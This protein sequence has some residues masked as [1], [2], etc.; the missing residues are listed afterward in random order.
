MHHLDNRLLLSQTN[1]TNYECFE[2]AVLK[3]ALKLSINTMYN[4]CTTEEKIREKQQELKDLE[5]KLKK[6]KEELTE[7][8]L[9]EPTVI[10]AEYLHE[11]LCHQNHIDWC[12][13]HYEKW[14]NL[15]KTY[16]KKDYYNRAQKIIENFA[17]IWTTDIKKII[18][19]ITPA[20]SR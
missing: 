8:M 20:L 17:K 16:T 19:I 11:K 10:L 3:S 7:V 5:A 6:E 18:E 9:S 12:G 13:R 4:T 1:Y 14:W 15:D 2:K